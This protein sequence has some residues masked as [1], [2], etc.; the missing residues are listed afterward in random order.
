MGQEKGKW[1]LEYMSGAPGGKRE[2]V[3]VPLNGAASE[4][5]ARVA[6][7]G[8]WDFIKSR[9]SSE[10]PASPRLVLVIPLVA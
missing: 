9:K 2:G 5:D 1:Y 6:A 3:K 7:Q 10:D 8:E 4:D